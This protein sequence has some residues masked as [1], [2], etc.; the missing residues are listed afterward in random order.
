MRISIKS[1][2]NNI[3]CNPYRSSNPAISILKQNT[4]STM[5][6]LCDVIKVISFIFKYIFYYIFKYILLYIF[7][8]I[9]LYIFK[10][11]I[12]YISLNI[13]Y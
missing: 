11:I 2:N 9:L 3:N 4:V 5:L 1:V 10:Y 12:Y 6:L 8:Y 7:Y 13:S